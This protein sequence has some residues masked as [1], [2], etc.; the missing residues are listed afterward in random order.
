MNQ[1]IAS[2]PP[3]RELLRQTLARTITI[4]LVV[5]AVLAQWPLGGATARGTSGFIT[6]WGFATL[7]AL[8]PSLGGHW[9]ELFFLNVLRPR[10]PA[11]RSTQTAA[12]IA[13]W[14][15]GGALLT[16]AM[17]LTAIT[18][19]NGNSSAAHTPIPRLCLIG[20][21]AFIAIELTVH[22]ILHLRR[23]SSFYSTGT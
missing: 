7:L 12:R 2:S 9:V 11:T 17:K 4:A 3:H 23:L 8:W 5:G 13:T 20:G 10:L 18:L 1:D 16:L 21:L 22:L 19:L 6:R 14:F 15:I